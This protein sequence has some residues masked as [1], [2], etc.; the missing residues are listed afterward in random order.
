V[1]EMAYDYPDAFFQ[2]RVHLT[3]RPRADRYSWPSP[4]N[5]CSGRNVR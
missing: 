3:A 2:P 5:G 1:Q 4:Q